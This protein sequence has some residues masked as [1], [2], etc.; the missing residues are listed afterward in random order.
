MNKHDFPIIEYDPCAEAVIN[1]PSGKDG[2]CLPE[3]A[4]VC[5]P[6]KTV[7]ALAADGPREPIYHLK[8]SMGSHPIYAVE[9]FGTTIAV[10]QPGLGASFAAAF[11]DEAIA[12]G[13][14]KVIACGT[15]GVL[16]GG[17]PKGM[18]VVPTSAVR[19]EGTSYHYLPPSREVGCTP[20]TIPFIEEVL[21]THN[22]HYVLGKTWTTD[23]FYRE[24][25][26]RVKRRREEGCLVVEMEASAIFAVA[27]FR[28]I[29]MGMLLHCCD[30]VS[31]E[32]WDPRGDRGMLTGD[33]KLF[34]LAVEACARL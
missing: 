30:D 11:L 18:V 10:F 7:D 28:G 25:P 20:E 5:F 34:W 33:D 3:R 17:M 31:G 27:Q 21:K 32:V 2:F 13:C 1:P 12:L 14:R 22:C 16:D 26:A 15:C 19:D 6:Q 9:A 8:S 23:A 4:V 29:Q 24:T